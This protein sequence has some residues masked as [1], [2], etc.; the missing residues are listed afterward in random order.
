[1]NNMPYIDKTKKE[2]RKL[3]KDLISFQNAIL[4]SDA[5]YVEDETENEEVEEIQNTIHIIN[6]YL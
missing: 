4:E 1:M 6:R 2:L 3:E 5:D